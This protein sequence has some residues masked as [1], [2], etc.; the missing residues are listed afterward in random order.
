[1]AIS[2]SHVAAIAA[3]LALG[4]CSDG[5][6][7]GNGAASPGS[8]AV[9]SVA[10]PGI[11]AAQVT[12]GA[13]T[14]TFVGGRVQQLRTEFQTLMNNMSAQSNQLGALRAQSNQT[15]QSYFTLIGAINARLQA[16]T[17]PGNPELVAAWNSAQGELDKLTADLGRLN[18]LGTEVSST[19]SQAAYILESVRATY[20]LSG[21]VDEDHR[22]LK[23]LENEVNQSI[24][25]VDRLL[26]ELSQDIN[27][28][29]AYLATERNNL[30][31][32]NLAIKNG[33][34]LGPSVAN[35]A[36]SAAPPITGAPSTF[37]VP[38]GVAGRR[39][40]VV[41]RFDESRVQ[42]EQQ[43]YSAVSEALQRR[44]DAMFDL[45]AISPNR[46]SAADVALNA[47]AS[48]KHAE[49]VLRALTDM[50]VTP[51]RVALSSTT[52]TAAVVNE[53]HL[54]VR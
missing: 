39:P 44:P 24:V 12:P 19:S 8:T 26:S 36:F 50:G 2:R 32:L 53:V 22:Q 17:T 9:S 34:M 51:G 30:V 31:T 41:I 1:M 52:S 33:R 43:L 21:A 42:Y 47:S 28:Q 13:P 25:L 3:F 27:R 7:S 37:A 20:G 4:G 40:L 35:R 10:L 46:G 29:N 48:K 15:A 14:G 38:P 5:L 49:T 23:V 16:G 45:V 11:P 18:S 54:Y 6:Y